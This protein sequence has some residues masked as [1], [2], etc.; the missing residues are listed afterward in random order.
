MRHR[1]S[2]GAALLA[3][4]VAACDG[5]ATGAPPD[6]GSGAGGQ[7][8][9]TAMDGGADTPA[10]Q[11]TGAPDGGPGED[12][13]AP[14]WP[15]PTGTDP[16]VRTNED[17][18]PPLRAI[19]AHDG[20]VVACA[21]G[22]VR[23]LASDGALVAELPLPGCARLAADGPGRALAITDDGGV[24]PLAIA[25]GTL[26]A[27]GAG[28]TPA[29]GSPRIHDVARVGDTLVGTAPDGL[30]AVDPDAGTATQLLDLPGARDVAARGDKA[31]VTGAAGAL[32]VVQIDGG[33]ATLIG[34]VPL[35]DELGPSGGPTW[36]VDASG[37]QVA[38][39]GTHGVALVDMDGAKPAQVGLI[40]LSGAPLDTVALDGGLLGVASW[41]SVELWDVDDPTAPRRVGIEEVRTPD[42]KPPVGHFSAIAA[43]DG[44]LLAAGPGGLLRLEVHPDAAGPDLSLPRATLSYAGVP[45]GEVSSGGYLIENEGEEPLVIWSIALGDPAFT[46]TIDPDFAGPV[47]DYDPRP[48]MVI[49]PGSLG[50]IDVTFTAASTE[51][52]ATTLTL[53][54][55]DPD[56]RTVEIP[57]FGNYRRLAVGD[58]APEVLV[59]AL[60]GSVHALSEMK[61]QV[62]YLKVF[63]GL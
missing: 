20:A 55:N 49:D 29:A 13:A 18:G 1:L 40:A 27:Q 2:S 36:S 44:A 58:P 50:F 47:A 16:L 54:T 34:E 28:Y 61:G 7:D 48:A 8:A 15:A 52:I 35:V 60:D 22:G 11:D 25:P 56:E 21:A 63:S 51:E 10:P 39:T 37:P 24:T 12:A 42:A 6:A 33:G 62:V 5:G 4:A 38:V 43:N 59:P 45:V 26:T 57:L 3:L 32:R 41:G 19:L 53:V 23:L 17:A 31:L 9:A 30:Y 14:E 46:L